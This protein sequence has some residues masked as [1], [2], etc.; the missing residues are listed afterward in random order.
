VARF[1]RLI[2]QLAGAF[3][4]TATVMVAAIRMFL[5]GRASYDDAYGAIEDAG[6]ALR[7]ESEIWVEEVL[8]NVYA[9]GMTVSLAADETPDIPADELSTE[10]HDETLDGF[11]E[12]LIGELAQATGNIAEDAKKAL[13]EVARQ[14][15]AASLNNGTNAREEARRM[16]EDL[17]KRGIKFTDR[18]GRNWGPREYA[19]MV[20]RTH[21]VSVSNQANLNTAAELG[22]PGVRV[23]DGGPGD[24]DE[25]C[26]QANGQ[27][28][29]LAYAT[30]NRLEHPNCR[31]A[32]APLPSTYDGGFDR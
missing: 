25:P 30:Q 27:A 24:V 4:D 29:R 11:I 15:L 26:Q 1:D 23:F 10:V 22:S 19:E 32:F 2:A 13:R 12:D 3:E 18:R 20:L 28:W 31:R 6:D 5:G 9:E 8:P 14:R 21:T 7:E 17:D 16:E